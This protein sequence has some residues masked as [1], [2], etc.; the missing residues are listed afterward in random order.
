MLSLLFNFALFVID[1]LVSE[2]PTE[3][4]ALEYTPLEILT[5]LQSYRL[6]RGKAMGLPFLSLAVK[7]RLLKQPCL[8]E[9]TRTL[10]VSSSDAQLQYRISQIIEESMSTDAA[11]NADGR[12]RYTCTPLANMI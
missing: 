1:I 10:Y 3:G 4:T 5:I 8:D 6:G 7:Q 12:I 11:I 2:C 9:A